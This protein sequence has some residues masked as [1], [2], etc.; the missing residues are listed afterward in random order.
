MAGT[1][2]NANKSKVISEVLRQE[3]VGGKFDGT[4]KLPSEHQLM[5]RFSVA[6]ETVRSALKDLIERDLISRKPGYG[7]YLVDRAAAIASQRFGVIVPDAYHPFYQMI[8][9]GLEDAARKR[10]WSVLTAALGCGT[11]RERALKAL[12]FAEICRDQRVGGVFVQPLQFFKDSERFNRALVDVLDAAGIPIVLLDSDYRTPPLRS[13]F[14]LVGVDNHEAGYV[15]AAHLL[16]QGAKHVVY[17]SNPYPSVTSL[18]RG[19]GAGLAVAAAGLRWTREN[20]VFAEP[21]DA[22]AVRRVFGTSRRPDAVVCVNDHVARQLCATLRSIGLEVPRDMLMAGMNDDEDA[23]A[24]IPPLTTAAQPCVEIGALA[25]RMMLDRI[26]DSSL[27]P[28]G[29]YLS[30]HLVVRESTQRVER[31]G[32]RRK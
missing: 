5:R 16:E 17:F 18:A 8:F 22:K 1:M 12:E 15:L 23:S 32:K 7:T 30:T 9:R 28:R 2:G 20:M 27:A 4:R 21:S 24:C 31:K 11:P 25:V 3:I 26:E 13:K 14:D 6:R 29:V 19:S 10:G